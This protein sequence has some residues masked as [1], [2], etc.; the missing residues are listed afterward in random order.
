MPRG[1]CP[2]PQVVIHHIIL[3][4]DIKSS[5]VSQTEE[6]RN[7]IRICNDHAPFDAYSGALSNQSPQMLGD[8]GGPFELRF[9]VRGLQELFIWGV[10][11]LSVLPVA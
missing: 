4:L 8:V 11:K 9:Q 6:R 5:I 7:A 10:S 3:Q 2:S 1:G